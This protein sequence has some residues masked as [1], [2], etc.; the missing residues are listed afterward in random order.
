MMRRRV[1]VAFAGAVLLWLQVWAACG[2]TDEPKSRAPEVSGRE[3]QADSMKQIFAT[4]YADYGRTS[5]VPVALDLQ[6]RVEWIAELPSNQD[7][8]PRAVLFLAGHPLVEGARSVT[9]FS[10]SGRLIWQIAKADQGPVGVF[11]GTLYYQDESFRLS[12]VN[13]RGE[14]VLESTYLPD[15]LDD[16]FPIRLFAP[17][18][19]D[20]LSVV[21]FTGGPQERPLRVM[22]E[23]TI[24]RQRMSEWVVE[25]DGDV[26]LL[27]PQIAQEREQF[28]QKCFALTQTPFAFIR[29]EER[30]VGK[31]CRSRWSPYH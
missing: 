25:I 11:G 26:E 10:D 16:R 30:R 14:K 17:R 5:Y 9:A 8:T 18:Q 21:Q 27:A 7:S 12:G 20:F 22:A 3:E 15:A 23:L 28:S 4:Y 2:S 31:E 1:M 13:L 19:G 6:G 24:Y 29:S